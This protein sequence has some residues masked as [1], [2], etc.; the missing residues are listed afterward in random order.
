MERI[1]LVALSLLLAAGIAVAAKFG[2]LQLD[3][4]VYLVKMVV[5]WTAWTCVVA[6][7]YARCE[8]LFPNVLRPPADED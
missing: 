1:F 7:I 2:F 5:G 6:M 4:L 8:N 3:Q